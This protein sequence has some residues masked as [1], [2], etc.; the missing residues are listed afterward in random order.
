[1]GWERL[2]SIP[3]LLAGLLIQVALVILVSGFVFGF[4]PKRIEFC[5]VAP[6]VLL[7]IP[8]RAGFVPMWWGLSLLVGYRELEMQDGY[9]R[10]TERVGP[11]WYGKRWPLG[12]ILR[13]DI[14]GARVE[15]NA[16]KYSEMNSR[17]ALLLYTPANKTGTLAWGYPEKLLRQV[18]EEIAQRAEKMIDLKGLR[19]IG[20]DEAT[21]PI[22][23]T[24][25]T[26]GDEKAAPSADA[27]EDIP[28]SPPRPAE[29]T[30]EVERFEDG[31]TIRVPPL[32]L[33]KGS[34]GL[35]GFS[36]LWNG[37]MTLFTFVMVMSFLQD[38]INPK[39]NIWVAF[40]FIGL[41]WTIGLMLLLTSIN[42]GRRHA[43]IAVAGGTLMVM[44]KGIFGTKQHEWPLEHVGAIDAGPSGM[45]VNDRPLLELQI[46]DQDG[47][48]F[49]ILGGRSDAELHWLAGILREVIHVPRDLGDGVP[50][51]PAPHESQ[52]D[53]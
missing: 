13:L 2:F 46:Y 41:F 5:F 35:F 19:D 20:E 31:V 3:L 48:K 34:G 12:D 50:A 6:L 43:A 28:A 36:L 37:F 47:D 33:R 17:F 39:D 18:A 24:T 29:T 9:L 32:G 22:A 30:I 53:E 52:A 10:T 23:V 7:A 26:I 25:S 14:K 15:K 16:P 51:P 11:L 8:T 27:T 38:N 44:Q 4:W 21:G 40:L 42:L 49:A 45:E 1:M